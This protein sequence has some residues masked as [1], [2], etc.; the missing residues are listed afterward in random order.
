ML[1]RYAS[2][3]NAL[4]GYDTELLAPTIRGLRLYENYEL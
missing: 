3:R 4:K 2:L 1:V